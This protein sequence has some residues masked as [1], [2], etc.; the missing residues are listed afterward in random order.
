MNLFYREQRAKKTNFA[1]S[2]AM[3]A[4]WRPKFCER[5]GFLLWHHRRHLILVR[6]NTMLYQFGSVQGLRIWS[7]IPVVSQEKKFRVTA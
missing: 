4:Q 5:F 1:L 6:T 7:G 3:Q 2:L